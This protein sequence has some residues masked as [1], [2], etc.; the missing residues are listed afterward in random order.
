MTENCLKYVYNS[1]EHNLFQS[2]YG[3][4][5]YGRNGVSQVF[6]NHRFGFNGM[7]ED[8]EIKGSKNSYDFGAR[9]YDP[10][11]G[12]WLSIDP[13]AAKYPSMSP[14]IFIGNMVTIA[15]DPNGEDIVIKIDGTDSRDPVEVTYDPK[16]SYDGDDALIKHT[17]EQLDEIN[18]KDPNMIIDLTEPKGDQEAHVEI[19]LYGVSESMD[20]GGPETIADGLE[21]NVIEGF[22]P[23]VASI[24]NGNYF[25]PSRIL[26]H[27]LDHVMHNLFDGSDYNKRSS[28]RSL[29][30]SERAI[31]TNAEE[32]LTAQEENELWGPPY[33]IIHKGG[34]FVFTPEPIMPQL[35]QMQLNVIQMMTKNLD[36]KSAV[37]D[38]K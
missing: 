18:K 31:W 19:I 4:V 7:E 33:R 28:D 34:E 29:P 24:E 30:K 21:N 38:H 1:L 12:R 10:R 3:T 15:K 14:Y 5:M 13:L 22:N 9:L 26:W 11:V 20:N 36:S 8:P 25:G 27:E 17:W 2:S 37:P 32:K 23:F 35:I 6:D 16:G